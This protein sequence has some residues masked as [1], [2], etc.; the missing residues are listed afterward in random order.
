MAKKVNTPPPV[1]ETLPEVP[2]SMMPAFPSFNQEGIYQPG[3]TKTELAT[4]HFIA[5]H[6]QAHGKVPS[7]DE[8][9]SLI[10]LATLSFNYWILD[11]TLP[12]EKEEGE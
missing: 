4:T 11:G 12:D 2:N 1:A 10:E 9:Q 7:A 8:L 3:L 5:A 6:I